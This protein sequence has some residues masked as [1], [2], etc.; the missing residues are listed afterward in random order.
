LDSVVANAKGTPSRCLFA[1]SDVQAVY[2]NREEVKNEEMHLLPG[3]MAQI[4]ST[5]RGQEKALVQGGL[6][7]SSDVI[8]TTTAC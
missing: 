5:L 7:S 8:K 1:P 4:L 2:G 3:L 6:L